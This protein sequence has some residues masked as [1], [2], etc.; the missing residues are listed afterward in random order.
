MTDIRSRRRDRGGQVLV[1]ARRQTASSSSLAT[2]FGD[3]LS[4][5][6]F[7]K[8]RINVTERNTSGK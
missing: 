3:G 8:W 6:G 2:S 1:S 7:A 4:T 5:G